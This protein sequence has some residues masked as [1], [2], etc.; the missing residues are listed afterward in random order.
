MGGG[1]TVVRIGGSG[2]TP[3]AVGNR[4]VGVGEALVV[5]PLVDE[6]GRSVLIA[7]RNTGF[8]GVAVVTVPPVLGINGHG[9]NATG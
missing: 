7:V 6:G 4:G 1:A 2:G 3:V 5:G 9:C 8:I